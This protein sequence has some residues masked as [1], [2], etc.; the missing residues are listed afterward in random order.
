MNLQKIYKLP[1]QNV[2]TN[3]KHHQLIS[4]NAYIKFFIIEGTNES[5]TD[6]VI[7]FSRENMIRRWKLINREV[8]LIRDVVFKKGSKGADDVGIRKNKAFFFNSLSVVGFETER[9]G[10]YRGKRSRSKTTYSF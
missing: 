9:L 10:E 6:Y 2:K 3:I 1:Y 5:P 4:L 7:Y 8:L